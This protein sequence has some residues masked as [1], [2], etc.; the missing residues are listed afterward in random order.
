MWKLKESVVYIQITRSKTFVLCD[1]SAID[2]VFQC[3]L[4]RAYSLPRLSTVW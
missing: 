1:S 3:T 4:Y 2:P